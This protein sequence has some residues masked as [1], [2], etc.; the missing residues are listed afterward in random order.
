MLGKLASMAAG[1]AAAVTGTRTEDTDAAG[2]RFGPAPAEP[3]GTLFV[4][5]LFGH[6]DSEPFR[7]RIRARDYRAAVRVLSARVK[8]RGI[9]V[10]FDG[11]V[12]RFDFDGARDGVTYFDALNTEGGSVGILRVS[13][14]D[15]RPIHTRKGARRGDA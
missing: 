3:V 4:L 2:C 15:G 10:N 14:E 7:G 8:V 12:V 11:P 13:R 5:S 6:D 1:L 9:P